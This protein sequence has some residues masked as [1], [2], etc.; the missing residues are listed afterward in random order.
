MSTDATWDFDS[1]DQIDTWLDML[2][3]FFRESQSEDEDGRFRAIEARAWRELLKDLQSSLEDLASNNATIDDVNEILQQVKDFDAPYLS[4]IG[5]WNDYFDTILSDISD[6]EETYETNTGFSD[7]ANE[8]GEGVANTAKGLYDEL[9]DKIT[10]CVGSPLDCIK[11]IGTAILDA[12]GI[13][14]ECQEMNDPFFCTENGPDAGGKTCWKD[15]VNFNLPGLPIPDI[16]LPP[17]VVDVGTYRD[18][19][20]AVKTV[21]KTIGDIIDGN[22][23]CGPDGDQECTV[24]QVLEDLGDWAREK[25]EDA[26]GGIDDATGQDVLDWLKGILG[27]ATAGI[28][29]AEIEEEVTDVLLPVTE[30]TK[31]CTDGEGQVYATVG[32]DEECPPV[33]CPEGEQD[34][35]NNCELTIVAKI[36]LTFRTRNRGTLFVNAY[37][38]VYLTL[39]VCTVFCFFC[40]W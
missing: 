32:V 6:A 12:G 24:G 33:P 8:V 30:E 23:S 21:G 36:L 27:P 5:E 38:G 25:W 3:D 16:P 37:C 31:D 11:K 14:E 18:F 7:Y 19:E 1:P 22:E 29:W 2:E 10:E 39:S 9:G 4:E 15:C 20:N 28:I 34:F 40:Y 17:G 13:P 26:V 35:G